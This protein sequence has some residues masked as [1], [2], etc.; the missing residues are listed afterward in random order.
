MSPAKARVVIFEDNKLLRAEL[1]EFLG[2]NGHQ[3]VGTAEDNPGARKLIRQLLKREVQVAIVDANLTREDRSGADGN[4]IIREIHRVAPG[5]KIV[6]YAGNPETFEGAD[7]TL[8]KGSDPE[9]LHHTI[10]RL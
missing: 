3:I 5:V 9:E 1:E 6:G 4:E 7:E 8:Q 2:N 10:E